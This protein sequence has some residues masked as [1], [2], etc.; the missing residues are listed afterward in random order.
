MCRFVAYLGPEILISKLVTE[1]E[2]SLIH[3]S[4]HSHER[5]EPLNGDGFGLAWYV[6]AITP[7]AA[8]FRSITPAW[9]NQNLDCLARV[10]SCSV[11]FAHVRAASPGLPVTETNTHPFSW[12]RYAF[13]HNGEVGGFHE[14]RRTLLGR[15]SHEPFRLIQG[16]TDS[17]HLFALFVENLLR[18]EDEDEADE[19]APV[20]RM[21]AALRDAVEQVLELGRA[22]GID[23]TSFLNLAVT[24]GESAVC[25]R[26]TDGPP[27]AAQTLY[28]HTGKAYSYQDGEC[29]MVTP[30][31]EGQAVI[32]ASEPLSKD[33]G[34]EAVPVN[35]MVLVPETRSAEVREMGVR[36]GG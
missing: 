29:R 9:S 34:W 31:P 24:N 27:E 6:P 32:V 1:P 35:H 18:R 4:F 2:S 28:C 26:V 14:I 7:D 5:E 36:R 25:C 15:L 19:V 12:G 33:P 3:Q 21:A 17:E 13:M 11:I 30:D 16:T 23:E 10:L 22:A 8:V 20:E